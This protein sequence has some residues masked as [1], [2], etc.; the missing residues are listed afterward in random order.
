MLVG[1]VVGVGWQSDRLGIDFGTSTT[2]A[3]LA[4][5]SGRNRPLLFDSSPLLVSSVFVGPDGS[6]LTGV[7]AERAALAAPD[8]L[9]PN[10]KRRIDEGAVWLGQREHR[11]VDLIGAVLTRVVSEARRVGD[12]AVESAVLTHPAAWGRSRLGALAHAANRA[13]LRDVDL[14]P[15]PV[16]AAMYYARVLGHAV[17]RDRCLVVYDLGAGTFD[18][19]VIRPSGDTF[20][21]V[22]NDGLDDVGG[23]D[24]DAALVGHARRLTASATAEW[25]RLDGPRTPADRQARQNLWRGARAA[26]ELLSR[27][28]TADLHVPLVDAE[29]HLTRD[30]FDRL[31]LP[32]LNRTVRLTTRL[33]T[34]T[35]VSPDQLA[36]LFLVGGASRTPLVNTLLHRALGVAPTALDHPELVV[37]EG[38]VH[39]G[40]SIVGASATRASASPPG[41]AK[42]ASERA[43]AKP[44]HL[45]RLALVGAVLAILATAGALAAL[46]PWTNGQASG[47]RFV[48]ELT[49][50]THGLTSIAFSPDGKILAAGGG[51]YSQIRL[52]DVATRQPLPNRLAGHTGGVLNVAFSPDGTVLASSAY[53]N[54]VRL[55]DVATSKQ[56]AVLDDQGVLSDTLAFSPDGKLLASGGNDRTVRLWT[57]A[58]HQ[59]IG[60]PLKVGSEVTAVVFTPDST[61]LLSG[62]QAG[63]VRRWNATNGAP[64]GGPL[65]AHN[66]WIRGLAVSPD[67]RA[68]ATASRDNTARLWN[69]NNGNPLSDPLTGH[70][71]DVYAVAFRPDGSTLATTSSDHT[72]RLWN[73]SNGRPIG[74]PLT[75]HNDAVTTVAF[76]RHGILASGSNDK[77]IRLWTLTH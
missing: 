47:A 23:L 1:E 22:A 65:N 25:A 10:P 4:E 18:V 55:W 40:T 67:G 53:D 58:T 6:V 20:E 63:K 3:V 75:G 14:V 34:Q 49:G 42:P 28:T 70:T 15:E 12:G 77:T 9:E 59:A 19:S 41:P 45:R 21:V 62:D 57:V 51:D 26:K 64:I 46:R 69:L 71:D 27:H 60:Q 61:M 54:T 38:S 5:P 16:A 33:L 24:L 31:A 8:G 44:R 32:Y 35:A 66:D 73:A 43:R 48:A 74:A 7:D 52:W 39:T 11:V 13:G 29:V 36:S 17:R 30:E 76:G 2:V 50:H 37:A 56:I 72:V 68:I